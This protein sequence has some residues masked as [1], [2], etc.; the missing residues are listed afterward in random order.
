MKTSASTSSCRP[1]FCVE[2]CFFSSGWFPTRLRVQGSNWVMFFLQEQQ[3]T[4]DNCFFCFCKKMNI[5]IQKLIEHK[6]T[7]VKILNQFC[8]AKS[9]NKL[10]D[11]FKVYYSLL[12][13]TTSLH[14]QTIFFKSIYWLEQSLFKMKASSILILH[15]VS[16]YFP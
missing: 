8:L 15:L 16:T 12:K 7:F 10:W 5:H 2:K 11:S 4:P 9:I 14:K 13:S 6:M 3:K 1:W